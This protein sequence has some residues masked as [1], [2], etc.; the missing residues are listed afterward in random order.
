[1]TDGDRCR[2]ASPVEVDAPARAHAKESHGT[3]LLH[4]AL[5]RRAGEHVKQ[6]GSVSIRTACASTFDHNAP[7]TDEET[8]EIERLVNDKGLRPTGGQDSRS[9]DRGGEEAAGRAG[10]FGEKYGDEV[11]VV[12]VGDGFSHGVLGG[13]H[14]SR[15]GQIGS[16]ARR[17]GGRGQ[18]RRDWTG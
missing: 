5:S 3:H 4:W 1:V 17:R 6:H 10:V 7:L 16:S 2:S 8:V 14:L 9:V 13:T 12:S 15:T 18:G 11:R